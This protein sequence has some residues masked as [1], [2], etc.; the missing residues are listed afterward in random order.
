VGRC[1]NPSWRGVLLGIRQVLLFC[2]AS[3]IAQLAQDYV[4][5]CTAEGDR[6]ILELQCARFLLQT[7]RNMIT[8][9]AAADLADTCGY[10]GVLLSDPEAAQPRS[11][12]A[13]YERLLDPHSLL[14]VFQHRALVSVHKAFNALSAS[15]KTLSPDAAWNSCALLLIAASR[16]HCLYIV[17][18]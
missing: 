9:K 14:D 11:G 18:K 7:V 3:G 6:I 13:V 2:T 16:S 15:L 10:L 8:K 4:T 1:V 12:V 5:Y 17:M